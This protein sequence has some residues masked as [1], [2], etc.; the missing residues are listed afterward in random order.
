MKLALFIHLL[1][2]GVWLCCV[3]A[4]FIC[5][6]APSSMGPVFHNEINRKL[7]LPAL[8]C[9]LLS[10]AY[11]AV[12]SPYLLDRLFVAKM[13]FAA[14]AIVATAASIR[15]AAHGAAVVDDRKTIH[16]RELAARRIALPCLLLSLGIGLLFFIA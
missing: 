4:A 1:S 15:F 9:V 12:Y 14:I 3:L 8:V 2:A 5:D 7:L 10:G 16:R 6:Q 11:M 13:V